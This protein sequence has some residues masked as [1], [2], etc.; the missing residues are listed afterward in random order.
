MHG[1]GGGSGGEMRSF[2]RRH[3]QKLARVVASCACIERDGATIGGNG[4]PPVATLRVLGHFAAV[5]VTGKKNG[6]KA[7]YAYPK[8]VDQIKE[9]TKKVQA[10]KRFK[11]TI[12][13]GLRRLGVRAN[14][15]VKYMDV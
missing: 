8:F 4:A 10:Q 5:S 12:A 1:S 2:A 15:I 14:G 9:K 13:R 6:K 7:R 3:R 11:L